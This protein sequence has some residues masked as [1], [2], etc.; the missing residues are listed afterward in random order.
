MDPLDA[1]ETGTS[2]MMGNIGGP[3]LLVGDVAGSSHEGAHTPATEA[4]ESAERV[5][6]GAGNNHAQLKDELAKA[7]KKPIRRVPRSVR[8]VGFHVSFVAEG[9]KVG[10]KPSTMAAGGT[11]T[12]PGM[13]TSLGPS[14]KVKPTVSV[15]SIL[16]PL[17][18]TASKSG[19]QQA[20]CA[21]QPPRAIIVPTRIRRR[22][23]RAR[24][25]S[26]TSAVAKGTGIVFLLL[27]I[28]IYISNPVLLAFL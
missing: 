3:N 15:G 22:R 2:L 23:R 12:I 26:L 5:V 20:G 7:E 27:L 1:M 25:R 16:L 11:R 8:P 19:Q 17:K 21:D 18:L 24:S 4:A 13:R 14:I 10:P 9:G 28:Y 6:K